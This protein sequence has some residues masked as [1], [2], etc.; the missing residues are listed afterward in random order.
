MFWSVTITLLNFVVIG[1]VI[2]LSYLVFTQREEIK[3]LQKESSQ[4]AL[5]NK[6]TAMR[7][8]FSTQK[9]DNY[10]ESYQAI[11]ETGETFH[12][13]PSTVPVIVNNFT[14]WTPID[15]GEGE[16]LVVQLLLV[17]MKSDDT[18][19]IIT[20][21][22]TPVV[23]TRGGIVDASKHLLGQVIEPDQLVAVSRIYSA[24]SNPVSPSNMVAFTLDP[25]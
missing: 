16:S 8:R 4:L 12:S 24:G 6:A 9:N 18:P 23:I 3:C 21:L 1:Y 17:K 13:V 14:V 19:E 11:T 10:V 7:D 15:M 2:Y 5:L 20:E 22:S 25:L